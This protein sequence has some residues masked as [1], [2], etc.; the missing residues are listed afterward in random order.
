MNKNIQIIL[1]SIIIIYLIKKLLEIYKNKNMKII[2]SDEKDILKQEL[3]EVVK[4]LSKS[5]EQNVL[6]KEEKD[7]GQ[8]AQPTPKI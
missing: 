4:E 8:V 5:G 6:P 7:L 1:F 3:S 2:K